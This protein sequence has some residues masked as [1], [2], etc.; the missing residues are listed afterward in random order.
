[1]APNSEKLNRNPLGMIVNNSKIIVNSNTNRNE[2]NLS[3]N[4]K[5]GLQL[6]TEQ[7]EADFHAHL[8]EMMKTIIE[9]EKRKRK[10]F[11]MRRV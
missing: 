3:M 5:N 7:N 1:M 9:K 6:I 8:K 11:E 10:R 4:V 2:M